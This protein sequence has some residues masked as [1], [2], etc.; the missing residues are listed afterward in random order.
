M[1]KESSGPQGRER[2][3][4]EIVR[5]FLL[6]LRTFRQIYGE[7]QK[8]SLLF[9]HLAEFVDDQGQ[10]ILFAL[11]ENC[12]SLYRRH[13]GE[14]SEK[15]QIFDLTVGTLFHMGM[16]M[17][18]DLYQLEF[19]GPKVSRLGEKKDGTRER[20]SLVAQFQGLLSRAQ[21]SLKEGMEEIDLL[22]MGALPRFQDLLREYRE[23]GLLL[24]F[25]GEERD[26]L[27]EVWG[28]GA[29]GTLLD[30]IYGPG[31]AQPERLAGESYFQ[32]A[33]YSRATQA[34]SRALEKNPSDAELQF[35]H[36]LSQ[37]LEQFYFFA[38][39]PALRS[40]EKCLSLAVKRDFL[41]KY[42]ERI[43]NVCR[44]VEE[45]FPGRRKSDLNPGLAK[46]ARAIQQELDKRFALS[47]PQSG[48]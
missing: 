38:P 44:R 5:H 42:R 48:A 13:E 9:S 28:E 16:K 25:L 17:R 46:K 39:L 1:E 47:P 34:F 20:G 35:L 4:V 24:R 8:G 26:L 6:T 18:E 33:F 7:Y 3:A 21:S 23:N 31:S 11:K 29:E 15:E 2:K 30:S 19:Y 45:E 43:Q 27:R 14:A 41:E 40:L 12:H 37:G 10:S 32:S 36:H 22:L